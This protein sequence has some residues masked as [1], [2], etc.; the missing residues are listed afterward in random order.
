TPT[1]EIYTPLVVGSVI[2]VSETVAGG[3]PMDK[4]G[5][6]GIQDGGVVQSYSGSYTNVVGLPVELV[7]KI[8]EEVLADE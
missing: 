8:I 4:A 7:K 2:C 5:S 6:Y 1:S 3:S